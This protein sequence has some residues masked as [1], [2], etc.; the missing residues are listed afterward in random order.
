MDEK[1][2]SEVLD[3]EWM[4]SRTEDT[5]A[6]MIFRPTSYIEQ[7][8]MRFRGIPETFTLKRDGTLIKAVS[9]PNDARQESAG[10]WRLEGDHLAFYTEPPSR[11]SRLL[12]IV[13]V[14]RDRLVVKK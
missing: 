2:L 5:E 10:R 14:E 4:H 13:S 3:R 11:P 1:D 12:H 7:K 6:E 9:A 8:G